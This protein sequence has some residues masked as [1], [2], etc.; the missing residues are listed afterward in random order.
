MPKNEALTEAGT[1]MVDDG[2]EPLRRYLRDISGVPTLTRE[3]EVALAGRYRL[4]EDAWQRALLSTP[5][6]ARAA[7]ERWLRIRLEER[8]TATLSAAHRDGSGVDP[9]PALDL[10]LARVERLLATRDR[11]VAAGA[12]ARETAALDASLG[13]A[14]VKANLST[15]VLE[16]IFEELR[17]LHLELAKLGRGTRARRELVARIGLEPAELDRRLDAIAADRAESLRAKQLF[18]RHNLK[19]VVTA[20]KAFRGMGIAFLDLIQ[21]GNLGLMRAVEK[22]DPRHGCKFSTYAVW[23]IRQA[24]I[25][26][27]QTHSR[28][29]RLPSHVYE[30]LLHHRRA[31]RALAS[32]IASPP[33]DGEVAAEMGVE[34][35]ELQQL[36]SARAPAQPLDAPIHPDGARSLQDVL[37][38]PNAQDT[39]RAMDQM[40]LASRLEGLL[41][42]LDGRERSVL[43]DRFGLAGNEELTL[44]EVGDRLG[45]SRE[46]VRQIE[47]Q[48]LTRLRRVATSLGFHTLVDAARHPRGERAAS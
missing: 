11:N 16:E 12:K 5:F 28:T 7:V 33:S 35:G 17:T 41:A 40:R 36:L 20:T 30:A 9:G 19:L 29:V 8:V 46:R 48:A 13:E 43:L 1:G 22:F 14:M 25:R 24:C 3:Q 2:A 39:S 34:V 37:E 21:E 26:A 6:A 23:W 38:D 15:R 32:R 47:A 45:L 27:V 10:A 44:R 42:R 31:M 18:I 4:H